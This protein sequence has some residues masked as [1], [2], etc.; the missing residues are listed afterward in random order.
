MRSKRKI[1]RKQ[2]GNVGSK[3][4]D[5]LVYARPAAAG[6]ATV[7]RE[8]F[9]IDSKIN[10]STPHFGYRNG[11]DSFIINFFHILSIL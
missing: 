4:S 11:I 7:D 2:V 6:P 8:E 3:N 10:N 1:L 5:P 9:V